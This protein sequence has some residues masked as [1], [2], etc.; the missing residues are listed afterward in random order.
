M[1]SQNIPTASFFIQH[2]LEKEVAHERRDIF[3]SNLIILL[4]GCME[5][6]IEALSIARG[7]KARKNI[8][9]IVI[10]SVIAAKAF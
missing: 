1:G 3:H 9:E 7:D 4:E 6:T 2:G 10:K 5:K 8:A